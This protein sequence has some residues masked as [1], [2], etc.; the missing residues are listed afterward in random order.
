MS[1]IAAPPARSDSNSETRARNLAK[2]DPELRAALQSAPDAGKWPNNDYARLLDLGEVVIRPDGTTIVKA[3]EA[4]KLFNERAR[5]LAEVNLPYN[6]SYQT[7]R[8]LQART[9]K[10]DGTVVAVKPAD[11][12]ITSPYKEFLMYDDAVA[13]S[14]SMPA[15]EDDSVIDYTY[16]IVTRPLLLPGHYSTYW[17]FSNI[18]PVSISR[19]T[20]Q[21]PANKPL[22][23]R[24]Y[25]DKTLQPVITTSA[26]GRTKTYRWERKNLPPIE[27][28]PGMPPI[29]DIRVW[30]ELSSIG[31]WQEIAQRFWSLAHPQMQPNVATRDTVARLTANK[32][33]DTEKARAIYDWVANRVRYV[34]VELGLSAIKPH[35]VAEV[36]EKLYGDCKD[37]AILLITMLKLAGISAHPAL[38]K[39]GELRPVEANLPSLS[40]FNHCIALA[41]VEGKEV[42][43]D[44]T[45][46]TCAFGDIPE[47][48][49]G[50][51]ALVIR[52]GK[53]QFQTIPP[54]RCDENGYLVQGTITLHA[55]GSATLQ[56][57]LTMRGSLG[58]QMRAAVRAITPERR[59]EMMQ[60][61]AHSIS[62]NADVKNYTLPDPAQNEAVYPMH[63]NMNAPNFAEKTGSLLL[64]PA[65]G[66]E[67]N[68]D[69]TPPFVRETRVW[70]IVE[71][72]SSRTQSEIVFVLPEGFQVVDIPAELKLTN[73]I[74][75]YQRTVTKSADGK[76]V[77]VREVVEQRPGS[78]APGDYAQL[79]AYYAALLKA[80]KSKIVLK[81]P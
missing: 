37:K 46:E 67:Y 68:P 56:T 21:T 52:E 6:A 24:V 70:P 69:R 64:V 25:N 23:Y 7:M 44:A 53:G 62:A 54:Y 77:M 31:S 61:I 22:I 8:I 40:A 11:I 35:A 12:R 38:L 41:E 13:L 1:A 4:L 76:T 26:D 33:N 14:F 30:M 72:R 65:S 20:V 55:D 5:P 45:A 10:K 15:I 34:G 63:L 60:R 51:Q 57:Q 80:G 27:I 73:P 2:L 29:N 9:I 17:G 66:T 19:Y 42:W 43:L 59:K 50:C 47:S 16:E 36:Q 18:E 74:Q 58:Q 39:A 3:R 32:K 28:E 79:R 49:R 71:Q 78:V 75:S 81:G 48:D